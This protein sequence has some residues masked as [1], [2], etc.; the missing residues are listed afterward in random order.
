MLSFEKNGS[1]LQN[2]NLAKGNLEPKRELKECVLNYQLGREH[3][4]VQ[5]REHLNH[6]YHIT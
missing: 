1:T 6:K 2:E 3:I 5:N 4:D